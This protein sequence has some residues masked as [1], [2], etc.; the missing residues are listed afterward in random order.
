MLNSILQQFMRTAGDL[1][2]EKLRQQIEIL[3]EQT[4]YAENR[5][6]DAELALQNFQDATITEQQDPQGGDPFPAGVAA[7]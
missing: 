5:L 1:K 7:R 6:R 4:S 2:N 3:K